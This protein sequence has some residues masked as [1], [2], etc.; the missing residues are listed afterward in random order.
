MPP[1]QTMN[2]TTFTPQK[3]KK[4]PNWWQ[5]LRRPRRRHDPMLVLNM[6]R[7]NFESGWNRVFNV[8]P[9]RANLWW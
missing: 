6:S 2:V 3:M 7:L 8:V 4:R 9:A 1:L 5:F